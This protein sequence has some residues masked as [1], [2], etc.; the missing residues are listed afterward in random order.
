MGLNYNQECTFDGCERPT[1]AHGLCAA[2]YKQRNKGQLLVALRKPGKRVCSFPDCGKPHEGHGYCMGHYQQFKKGYE[3][4]PLRESFLP[5]DPECQVVGC[6]ESPKARNYCDM[7]LRRFYKGGDPG[8]AEAYPRKAQWN[9][10]SGGYIY[11][12]NTTKG[13]RTVTMQHRQ[14][15]E[16]HLGRPLENHE[17]VHHLNGVRDDNRLE[18][19]ELWNTSQPSGQRIS[20]K[21]SWAKELLRLYEPEPLS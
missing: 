10:N 12:S 2:H 14:V 5:Q 18:N 4:K 11:K 3:L 6:S 15:M 17:N 16:E 7:H 1:A 20:D 21:V 9:V 19:L 8:P 13:V